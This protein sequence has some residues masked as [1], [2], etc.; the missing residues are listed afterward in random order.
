MYCCQTLL[1][2]LSLKGWDL[3]SLPALYVLRYV[4]TWIYVSL[5]DIGVCLSPMPGESTV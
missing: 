3:Q 2:P 5:L 1:M 4:L